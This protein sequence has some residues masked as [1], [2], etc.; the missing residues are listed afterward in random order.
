VV[1]LLDRAADRLRHPGP[2]RGRGPRSPGRPS[3]GRHP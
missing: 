2:P 1:G 3:A